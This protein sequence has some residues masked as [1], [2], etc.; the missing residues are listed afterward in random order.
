M[1]VESERF[2]EVTGLCFI[3]QSTRLLHVQALH[4]TAKS[5]KATLQRKDILSS[6]GSSEAFCGDDCNFPVY[7]VFSPSVSLQCWPIIPN[8]YGPVIDLTSTHQLHH[9][10]PP[11]L[12][13]RITS[14]LFPSVIQT[15]I[16]KPTPEATPVSIQTRYHLVTCHVSA[17]TII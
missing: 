4:L 10:P 9:F 15:R 2:R 17:K 7:F 6:A 12:L 8:Q 5:Y 14:L 11:T 1:A 16:Q 13:T 3:S